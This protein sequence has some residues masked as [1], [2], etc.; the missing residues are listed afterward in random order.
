MAKTYTSKLIYKL[1]AYGK[2]KTKAFSVLIGSKKPLTARELCIL[3][4]IKYRSLARHLPRWYGFG[5]VERRVHPIS[6]E[7]DYSY[8]LTH[9]GRGCLNAYKKHLPM[10]D[11]FMHELE[12]WQAS[13]TA[14]RRSEYL[15]LT[16][17]QFVPEHDAA[18]EAFIGKAIR[19]I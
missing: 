11:T 16:F 2:S 4:G 14:E 17:T 12:L 13:L 3:T 7:G 10:Y 9:K 5:L 1:G 8:T 6:G 19:I 15:K 18:V